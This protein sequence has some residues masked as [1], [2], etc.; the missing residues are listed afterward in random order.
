MSEQI[1]VSTPDKVVL[2]LLAMAA[3]L[4]GFTSFEAAAK[5]AYDN[6]TAGGFTDAEALY[7]LLQ[8]TVVI[9][10]GMDNFI[11]DYKKHIVKEGK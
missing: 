3:L 11:N 6:A 5:Q 10:T 7:E 9:N 2:R 8:T 1:N 4:D